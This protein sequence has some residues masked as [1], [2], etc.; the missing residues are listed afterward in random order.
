VWCRRFG[1][2]IAAAIRRDRPA[3]ADKWHLDEVVITIAGEKHW[4]WRAFDAN[5]DVLEILVQSRRNARAATRFLKKLMRRWGVPRVAVTDKLRVMTL[6]S[7]PA[8]PAPIT[9]CTRA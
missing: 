8:A 7:V 2:Q 6:P 5:G 1:P 4:L 9:A 3:A